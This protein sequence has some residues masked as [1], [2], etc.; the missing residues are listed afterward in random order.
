MRSGSLHFVDKDGNKHI[1]PEVSFVLFK[2]YE[3]QEYHIYKSVPR[4]KNLHGPPQ[5]KKI[6]NKSK[7]IEKPHFRQL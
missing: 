1:A 5:F 4:R 6:N 2:P 7:P 3:H